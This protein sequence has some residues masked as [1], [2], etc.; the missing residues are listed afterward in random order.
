M[1]RAPT[2]RL[3]L[4]GPP[5]HAQCSVE[6]VPLLLIEAAVRC[7]RSCWSTYAGGCE[8]IRHPHDGGQGAWTACVMC[9]ASPGEWISS[10][11][12]GGPSP[13]GAPAN[14]RSVGPI[15]QLVPDQIGLTFVVEDERGPADA[16]HGPTIT[17]GLPRREKFGVEQ[18]DRRT[19]AVA[20]P[21]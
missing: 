14:Q 15:C 9:S 20:R 18:G 12:P 8:V 11:R 16:L 1:R 13:T 6:R 2:S 4:T 21:D 3:R 19:A 7:D 10:Q 17:A 5:R